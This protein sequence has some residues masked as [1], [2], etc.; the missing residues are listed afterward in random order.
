M[1]D[2]R[3]LFGFPRVVA[4]L[5]LV[6]SATTEAKS[7]PPFVPVTQEQTEAIKKGLA[8]LARQ[9]NLRDGSWSGNA[10]PAAMTGLSGLALLAAGNTP[11]QGEYGRHVMRAVRWFLKNQ[12]GDGLLGRTD[13]QPMY[14]HGFGALF[15][16][17][18]YGMGLDAETSHQ[19]KKALEKAAK[20][21]ARCQSR[22]GGWYYTPNSEAHEGSVTITQAQA[23]RGVADC[24]VKVDPKCIRK[25]VEYIKGSQNDDGSINYQYGRGNTGG[26]P[27]LT[28]A[29]VEVFHSMGM[30]SKSDKNA[31]KALEWLMKFYRQNQPHSHMGHDDYA[32][33]YAAQGFFQAGE[34]VFAEFYPQIRD[35]TLKA[36]RGDG[37][38]QGSYVGG[39]YGTALNLLILE[40]PWQLLPIFQR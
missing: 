6:F 13:G 20:L 39:V 25:C 19:V 35:R 40:I 8:W 23:L 4:G 14:G 18:A 3:D 37:S 21:T 17:Q 36:Q 15:L 38:W 33:F 12:G 7:S 34:E 11:G 1:R 30:Y 26:R 22:E 2:V 28:A 24:G 5:V 29:G 9:Q 16:S 31:A 10:Y 27:A 32:H